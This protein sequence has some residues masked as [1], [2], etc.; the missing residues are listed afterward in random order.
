MISKKRLLEVD[1]ERKK[2]LYNQGSGK[3]SSSS[4]KKISIM[5]GG[6]VLLFGLG[7]IFFYSN[8]VAPVKETSVETK[9][10]IS[11]IEEQN[12][13]AVV[14]EVAIELHPALK[15]KAEEQIKQQEKVELTFYDDLPNSESSP[16]TIKETAEVIPSETEQIQKI[17]VP[18]SIKE[19]KVVVKNYKKIKVKEVTPRIITATTRDYR[20]QI[21]SFR[22]EAEAIRRKEQLVNDNFNAIIESINLGVK[23]LWHR[24]YVEDYVSRNDAQR[25]LN[26]IATKYNIKPFIVKKP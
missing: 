15:K 11:V 23:G 8:A 3:Y 16:L 9:N 14:E 12:E 26:K 13:V 19:K 25:E 7:F 2:K 22:D 17:P 20:I 18:P 6:L 21:A 4:T 24:V 5:A 1:K 10:E